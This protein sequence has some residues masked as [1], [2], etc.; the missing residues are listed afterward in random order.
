MAWNREAPTG[1]GRGCDMKNKI[2][3]LA[4]FGAVLWVPALADDPAA[5]NAT[6]DGQV[7]VTLVD[8][9]TLCIIAPENL[10]GAPIVV[11]ADAQPI[12]AITLAPGENYV[13]VGDVGTEVLA[14]ASDPTNPG[15]N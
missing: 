10:V 11:T 14:V 6:T 8:P 9:S 13:S 3:A 2:L 12:A 1:L 5:T 7:A 4:A 15:A